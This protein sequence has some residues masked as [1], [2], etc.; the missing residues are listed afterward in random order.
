VGLPTVHPAY[1]SWLRWAFGPHG[2][3]SEFWKDELRKD[4]MLSQLVLTVELVFGRDRYVRMA[5]REVTVTSGTD[6]LERVYLPI[7]G[8]E[9]SVEHVYSLGVP[10]SQARSLPLEFDGEMVDV[11]ALIRAGRHLAGVGEVCLQVDGGDWDH[12]RVLL[13][14]EMDAGVEFDALHSLVRTTLT[15]PKDSADLNLTPWVVDSDRW[16][17]HD[18]SAAGMRYPLV[19][20]GYSEVPALAVDTVEVYWL[21]CYGHGHTIDTSEGVMVDGTAYD[22]THAEYAWSAVET[23]DAF[24]VPVTVIEFT[25]THGWDWSESV[26]VTVETDF[27]GTNLLDAIEFLV[28]EFSVLSSRGLSD[29]LFGRA[30]ARLGS[31]PTEVLVNASGSDDAVRALEYVEGTLLQAFPM[32][33]MVWDIG[34]YGPVVSDRRNELFRMRLEAGVWPVLSRASSVTETS[35]SEIFNDF[36]IRYSYSTVERSYGS[37]ATRSKE[38]SDLCALSVQDHGERHMDPIDAPFVTTTAVGEY[39]V[40]WLV[41]HLTLPS[42]V[43]EYVAYPVLLLFLRRGDNVEITD[44]DFGWTEVPATVEGLTYE[45]G[46]VNLR[47]RVWWSYFNLGGGSTTGAASGGGT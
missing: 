9:P 17:D 33:S 4:P 41:E 11:H 46:R 34:G 32:V 47:L 21:V 27:G 36:T 25:G 20:G 18:D 37:V 16:P 43:V 39:V 30:H 31:L 8:M 24:G 26:N 3:L 29:T 12:R 15:D 1:R 35:R 40:D 6:G 2:D 7:L 5:T 44:S 13:R 23:S 14:G 28:R 19:V 22:S 38:N 42:Y 10:T 45:R